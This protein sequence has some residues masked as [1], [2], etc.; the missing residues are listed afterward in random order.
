MSL[1]DTIL[2]ANDTKLEPVSVPEW[3]A[4]VYV[5]VMSL[6][7][8]TA[9]DRIAE[10]DDALALAKRATFIIRDEQGN[11]I[12]TEADAPALAKKSVKALRRI[13]DAHAKL[14]APEDPGKN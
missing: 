3:N 1:K 12:F 13:I 14:N 6:E 8:G 5:K 4:T 10:G 11:R 7:E 2:G 9:I